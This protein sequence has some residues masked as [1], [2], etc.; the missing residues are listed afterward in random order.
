MAKTRQH[1]PGP[2]VQCKGERGVRTLRDQVCKEA[3][4]QRQGTEPVTSPG[5]CCWSPSSVHIER[6]VLGFL[7]F[8][9]LNGAISL[10]LAVQ[11]MRS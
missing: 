11:Y 9:F 4:L 1:F 10:L 8:L 5:W 7:L 3:G 2:L 6:W